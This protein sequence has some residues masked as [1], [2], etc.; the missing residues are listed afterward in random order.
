MIEINEYAY[1]YHA[2][3]FSNLGLHESSDILY[4]SYVFQMYRKYKSNKGQ[5]N[6]ILER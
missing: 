1:Y 5:Y 3:W 6:V 4:A 2:K